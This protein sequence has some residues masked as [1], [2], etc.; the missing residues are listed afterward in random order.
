MYKYNKIKHAN[1]FYNLTNKQNERD[2]MGDRNREG[3]RERGIE[4][5]RQR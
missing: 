1:I 3:E 5:H 4:R 2:R